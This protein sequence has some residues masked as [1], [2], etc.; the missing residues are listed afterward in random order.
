TAPAFVD[1][2]AT[3]PT[4]QFS[5]TMRDADGTTS[6]STLTITITD[7]GPTLTVA[8]AIVANE[9]SGFA[10]SSMIASAVD[11]Q[12]A[13]KADLTSNITG[14]SSDLTYAAVAGATAEGGKTLYYSVD[15]SNKGVLHAYIDNNSSPSAYGAAENQKLIFT[16]TLDP[17]AQQYMVDMNGKLD[18]DVT[19]VGATFT[20]NIGSN[21]DY[22]IIGTDGA[23]YKPGA[24]LPI[25][26]TEAVRVDSTLGAIN[27]STQGI[28][29]DSQWIDKTTEL[30]TF[31]VAGVA[32]K[33]SVSIDIKSVNPGAGSGWIKWEVWNT[34]GT[35]KT[36]SG[37]LQVTDGV[38]TQIPTTQTSFGEIRI[39]Y[40]DPLGLATAHSGATPAEFRITG[41]GLVTSQIEGD[42]VLTFTGTVVDGDGTVSAKDTFA[43]HFEGSTTLS[44]PTG[45]NSGG[46]GGSDFAETIY[47]GVGD[48]ILTGG[49][50][51]DTFKWS[52][53]DT[54]SDKI[55]D[56]NL[57]PVALGGDVLDLKDLLV[58]EHSTAASLDSYLTFSA[59]TLG[60]TVITVDAN[61]GATGGTGQTITLENVQFT[62]L[63][64]Y[65]NGADDVAIITKLLNDGNLKTD[66]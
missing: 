17:V 9:A 39:G 63:Q 65:A 54:G 13:M 53:N 46:V 52:L 14:W 47:A 10:Y 56:F 26:V 38:M 2:S 64:T 37:Y 3:N 21:I 32:L 12:T 43:V 29:G 45:W 16:L 8:D 18:A 41:V 6:S 58:G 60:Q 5:Y 49:G 15:P 31:D 25:G 4:E 51:S 50:G 35:A 36:D 11:A 59:N 34:D 30:V 42:K 33:A 24:A 19:D 40:A 48:D 7:T 44:D 23:M 27:T 1:N 66:I 57:T 22:L 28:S 61:A 20:Q 62:A 55:T